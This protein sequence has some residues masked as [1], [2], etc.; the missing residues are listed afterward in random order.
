[1]QNVFKVI[2]II[3]DFIGFIGFIIIGIVLWRFKRA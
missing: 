2:I 3:G 1:M